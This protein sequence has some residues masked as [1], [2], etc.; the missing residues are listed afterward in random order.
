MSKR[1]GIKLFDK[2]CNFVGRVFIYSGIFCGL[3]FLINIVLNFLEPYVVSATYFFTSNIKW[4]CIGVSVCVIMLF[5]GV[6]V[7]ESI[8]SSKF[9]KSECDA[10]E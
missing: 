4:V 9:I 3:F 10:T 2:L 6:W 8:K 7:I 5:G 1:K